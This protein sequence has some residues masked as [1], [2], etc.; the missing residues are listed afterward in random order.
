MGQLAGELEKFG[1]KQDQDITAVNTILTEWKP[2]TSSNN[3][4]GNPM[5]PGALNP[6]IDRRSIPEDGGIGGRAPSTPND[7]TLPYR[8]STPKDDGEKEDNGTSKQGIIDALRGIGTPAAP[9]P[10][11]QT[12]NPLSQMQNPLNRMN[13][14]LGQRVPTRSAR[15]RTRWRD[16]EPLGQP[17][18]AGNPL[19]AALQQAR[20]VAA[21]P[22]RRS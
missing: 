16:A 3:S 6:P 21:R 7:R 13:S 2:P 8:K 1:Q 22:I 17:G 15:C 14:P 12:P 11:P 9:N 20:T 19:P 18:G 5:L 10:V 4:L